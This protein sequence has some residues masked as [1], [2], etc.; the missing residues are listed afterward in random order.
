M[1]NVGKQRSTKAERM[2]AK[3]ILIGIMEKAFSEGKVI[4]DFLQSEESESEAI[5]K[6]R[7]LHQ[8]LNDYRKSLQKKQL[9]NYQTLVKANACRILYKKPYTVIVER[10]PGRFSDR[11]KAILDVA[12]LVPGLIDTRDTRDTPKNIGQIVENVKNNLE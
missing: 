2:A 11:T 5:R 9:E 4:I 8:S 12:V 3:M 1:S 7:I 10:K 6:A